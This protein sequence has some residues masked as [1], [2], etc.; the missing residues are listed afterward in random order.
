MWRSKRIPQAPFTNYKE[1]ETVQ[2]KMTPYKGEWMNGALLYR[3]YA[4]ET[5]KLSEIKKAYEASWVDGI[6]LVCLTGLKDKTMLDELAKVCKPSQTL[7]QV[8]D[9]RA[10]SYDTAYPDYTPKEGIKEMIAYAH[11]LGFKVSIHCNMIGAHLDTEEYKAG[12]SDQ[13]SLNAFTQEPMI[14]KYTAYGTTYAFGQINQA[15][16]KWQDILVEKF[17]AA[18]K[19]LNV[20]CIHLDQSLICFNDGR[21]L[22]NG[23]TSMQGNVELQRRPGGNAAR[24]GVQRRRNQRI[25]HAICQLFAAACVWD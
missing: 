1:F 10:K 5:F 15:S 11:S 8:D 6:Q 25:Q 24:C 19:A 4:N 13:N 3:D 2:W 22:V 14:E 23:M 17:T 18:V 12:L 9:W 7:L 16:V 21:G 20:D